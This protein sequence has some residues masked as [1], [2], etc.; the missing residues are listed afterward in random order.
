MRTSRNVKLMLW[1][2]TY[3]KAHQKS[4]KIDLKQLLAHD[5][6]SIYFSHPMQRDKLVAEQI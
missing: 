6:Y 3:L 4:S 5:I 1:R 2:A